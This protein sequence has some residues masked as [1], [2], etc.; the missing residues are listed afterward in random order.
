MITFIKFPTSQ[1]RNLGCYM[2]LPSFHDWSISNARKSPH[3]MVRLGSF[4]PVRGW[5]FFFSSARRELQLL[6]EER[7]RSKSETF[8]NLRM[9]SSLG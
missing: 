7:L 4:F 9:C 5:S 3:S 1:L 6:W 2:C 8:L